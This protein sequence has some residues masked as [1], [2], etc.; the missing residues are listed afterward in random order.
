MP[1]ANYNLRSINKVSI[2][3]FL[4]EIKDFTCVYEKTPK[5][6]ANFVCINIVWPMFIER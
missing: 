3:V 1:L 5:H 2:S 4:T 6:V